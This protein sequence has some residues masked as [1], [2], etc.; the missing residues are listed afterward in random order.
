MQDLK[1]A[2]IQ[3]AL[4][5]HNASAN[6]AM[7]EEKI[8]TVDEQVDII[9]LPEM[10]T[11]GFSMDAKSLAEVMGTS[12]VKWM[13]Q[14]AR[15]K[16]SAIVGSVII[17]EGGNYYNRLI[18]MNPDGSYHHYDKRHLFRMAGE[19]ESYIAGKERLLIEYKDWKICPL[20]CYDLRFPVWSRNIYSDKGYDFDLMIFV[21]NWPEPR[22]NAWDTLL[23]AR[24]IEN[25]SYSIGV[26]RVGEDG[27][28][29]KYSGHSAAYDFKGIAIHA[30]REE[31][32]IVVVN[33]QYEPLKT[34]R[35]RF[36]FYLD[37]DKFSINL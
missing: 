36:P 20:I 13:D 25:L 12:T 23:Q 19:H 26:N 27:N 21:A 14:M 17:K 9:I 11:T 28:N 4:H 3:S 34:F 6:R 16:K 32:E 37:A 15:Q 8:W 30:P 2:F 35:E 18:W 31:E 5:W 10:F 33:L 29:V 1:I 22:V 7:F 24:A